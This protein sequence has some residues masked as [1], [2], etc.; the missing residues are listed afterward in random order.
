MEKLTVAC[1]NIN[2]YLNRGQEYVDKLYAMVKRNLNQRFD[3]HC[4]N[5]NN[6]TGWWAN[7]NH[8]WWAKVDL[9]EPGKFSGRVL[10][11]DLDS[12][13]TGPLDQLVEHK[14]IIDMQYWDGKFPEYNSSVMVWDAGE[15]E[16][17]FTKYTSDIPKWTV[18]GSKMFKNFEGD[19]E[20]IQYISTWNTFP[21]GMVQSYKFNCTEILQ[22]ECKICT[23]HGHPKPHEVTTGWV[24]EYWQL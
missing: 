15:H 12:V 9:F 21:P 19:Q 1:V 23:F 6:S 22:K 7:M 2:N 11:I 5:E 18:V 4:I 8:G 13:I 24:P 20:W 10:Y 16:E 3:F 14:G 17:I